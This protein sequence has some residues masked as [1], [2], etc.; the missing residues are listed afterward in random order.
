M[1]GTLASLAVQPVAIFIKTVQSRLKAPAAIGTCLAR[2]V[3]WRLTNVV[4]GEDIRSAGLLLS[5]C[6][7]TLVQ[8]NCRISGLVHM[9]P[10]AACWPHGTS[11][12]DEYLFGQPCYSHG[13]RT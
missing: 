11:L 4:K 2:A 10:A 5:V 12:H 7:A 9:P 13:T 3:P 8:T 6:M 1:A